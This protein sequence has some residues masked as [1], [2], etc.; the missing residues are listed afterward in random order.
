MKSLYPYVEVIWPFSW[1]STDYQTKPQQRLSQP[2]GLLDTR[3]GGDVS[4]IVQEARVEK[5]AFRLGGET[6]NQ[7]V[8]ALSV[9]NREKVSE[10]F[11]NT[12]SRTATKTGIAVGPLPSSDWVGLPSVPRCF[13]RSPT[14]LCS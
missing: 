9:R 11:R 1:D 7:A 2:H 3:L 5:L 8:W 13:T 14:L 12:K 6:R 4:K 10:Q